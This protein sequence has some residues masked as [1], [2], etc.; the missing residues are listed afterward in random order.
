MRVSKPVALE[1]IVGS[2]DFGYLLVLFLARLI[3][4]ISFEF[5]KC[6]RLKKRS[7]SYLENLLFEKSNKEII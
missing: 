2:E 5:N 4:S 1:Y 7:D 3:R 6:Q